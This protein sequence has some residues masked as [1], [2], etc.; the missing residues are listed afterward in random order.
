MADVNTGERKMD[1]QGADPKAFDP[2]LE[3]DGD[4]GFF[5][6]IPIAACYVT[7]CTVACR[8]RLQPAENICAGCWEFSFEIVV[9]W[10]DDSQETFA[11]QRA[12]MAKAYVPQQCK[13]LVLDQ[14]CRWCSHLI[15]HV[16]PAWIYRV[17]KGP[18]LPDKALVK[19][20]RITEV[21]ESYGY[22]IHE[23]GLDPIRRTYWLMSRYAG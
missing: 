16:N 23:E 22:V 1:L 7:T 14:V 4:G 3:S 15:S 19:H 6:L 18:N 9:D 13:S 2:V 20:Y 5:I 17:T 21:I 11:T 12:D 8:V 10:L